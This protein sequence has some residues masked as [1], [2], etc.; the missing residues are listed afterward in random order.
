MLSNQLDYIKRKD[1]E[2]QSSV[3]GCRKNDGGDHG[4]C[5]SA[6]DGRAINAVSCEQENNNAVSS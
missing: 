5:G 2:T 6:A 4:V 1:T 3:T